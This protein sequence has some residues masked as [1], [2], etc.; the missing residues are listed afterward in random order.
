M[1]AYG[2]IVP[3][4]EYYKVVG[5]YLISKLRTLSDRKPN[6]GEVRGKGLMIG[7]ELV[8]DK[9]T[10][11]PLSGD[12]V[13]E[14]GVDAALRGL[15]LYFRSNFLGIVPPLIIDET[16]ADEIASI[17]DKV[18]DVSTVANIKR[19]ARLARELTVT[20]LKA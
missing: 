2:F 13:Q 14:L 19:K 12:L 1:G 9:K 4:E 20:K 11:E 16:I 5:E 8:K 17:L 10:R 6:I 18:I 7:I 3:P 15:L